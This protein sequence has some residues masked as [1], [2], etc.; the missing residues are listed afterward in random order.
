VWLRS[1]WRVPT[2][3]GPKRIGEEDESVAVHVAGS[4]AGRRSRGPGHG[5][6]GYGVRPGDAAGCGVERWDGRATGDRRPTTTHP[7]ED[8]DGWPMMQWSSPSYHGWGCANSR[9]RT[10]HACRPALHCT[11][12]Q[13]PAEV[14]PSNCDDARPRPRHWRHWRRWQHWHCYLLLSIYLSLSL[15]AWDQDDI[16]SISTDANPHAV[17]VVQC[18]Y[19]VLG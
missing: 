8:A 17:F 14:V 5:D 10:G 12:L 13:G 3:L 6:C 16:H 15:L 4:M 18:E 9:P 2:W 19:P 11:A 7:M 1:R